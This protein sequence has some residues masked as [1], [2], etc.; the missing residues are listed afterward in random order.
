MRSRLF[1]EAFAPVTLTEHGA[2]STV[3]PAKVLVTKLIEILE[4]VEKLPVFTHDSPGSGH[5]LQVAVKK[6]KKGKCF[7]F[8][9]NR[10]SSSSS[11]L[12]L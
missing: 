5:G 7:S 1:H 6:K 9:T 10:D 4:N 8:L 3:N 2:E 12:Q 11:S